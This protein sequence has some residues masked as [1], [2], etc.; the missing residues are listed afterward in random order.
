[1][2]LLQDIGAE[3]RKQHHSAWMYMQCWATNDSHTVLSWDS[4]FIQ[5]CM[6]L[7]GK[8]KVIRWSISKNIRCIQFIQRQGFAKRR[9]QSD[10]EGP[11]HLIGCVDNYYV[12]TS[13]SPD[14][15][16]ILYMN[17]PTITV[18][19]SN[20]LQLRSAVRF[21]VVGRTRLSKGFFPSC[22]EKISIGLQSA[23]YEIT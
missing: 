4:F 19:V 18:H 1:M 7:L 5:K 10:V 16:V 13:M 22:T 15:P 14:I 2:I 11:S 6:Y 20:D 21:I 17:R 8:V 3:C 9:C 23:C 12:S